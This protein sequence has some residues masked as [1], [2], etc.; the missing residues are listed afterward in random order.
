MFKLSRDHLKQNAIG[1]AILLAV[2]LIC[3]PLAPKPNP[4]VSGI[5]LPSAPPK[6]PILPNQVQVLETMPAHATV[7]GTVNTKIYYS[8]LS[9]AEE[10]AD[11]NSSINYAK[12]LA[13]EAGANAIVI[14]AL[15][16]GMTESLGPLNSF[17][18]QS[19]AVS[20]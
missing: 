15:R 11:M 19:Y 8:S 10:M 14:N 5:L 7:L 16:S 12:T 18:T 1:L 2:G 9:N 3:W 6:A 4:E 17:V 20:F 13:A